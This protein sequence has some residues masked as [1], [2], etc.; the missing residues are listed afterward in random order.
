[1]DCKTCTRCDTE[2]PLTEFGKRTLKSGNIS[3]KSMCKSCKRKESVERRNRKREEEAQLPDEEKEALRKARAVKRRSSYEANREKEIANATHWN[4]ENPD[5]VNENM[6]SWRADNKEHIAEYKKQ[7]TEENR[8]AIATTK[9]EYNRKNAHICNAYSAKRRAMVA[10]QTPV[11]ADREQLEA[12]HKHCPPGYDVD[13]T[14]PLSAGG[15][16]TPSNLCYLP[17]G[18][19]RGAKHDKLPEAEILHDIL[20]NHA[21]IPAMEVKS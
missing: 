5:R 4:Q 16:N 6:A 8:E 1:M 12:I 14:W 3:L 15:L 20:L 9:K 19:N 18:L 13:H 21:I 10:G 2:K 11:D 17:R 7:Y